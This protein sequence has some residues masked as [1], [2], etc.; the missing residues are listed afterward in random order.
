M[1]SRRLTT[2]YDQLNA[3]LNTGTGTELA[4]A[5][6]NQAV[7][8]VLRT[9]RLTGEILLRLPRYA[10]DQSTA[11]LGLTW[12]DQQLAIAF[13]PQQLTAI[14]PDQLLAL[15]SHEALHVI[16]RHPFRYANRADQANVKVACDIAVNQYLDQVPAGTATLG[17]LRRLLHRNVP[18]H[19]DSAF[20]LKL[21]EKA[22]LK[23]QP[24]TDKHGQLLN[25]HL[26]ERQGSRPRPAKALPQLESHLG[27]HGESSG[28]NRT[29]RLGQLQNLLKAAWRETPQH[30]RGLLPGNIR[31]ALEKP[32]QRPMMKW[33]RQLRLDLG[34]VA[35]GYQDSWGRFNRRQPMRMDLPGR[36]TKYVMELD[37]FV[38]N[39]GSMPNDKIS[40]LLSTINAL[41]QQFQVQATVYPFDAKVQ[42]QGIQQLQP[43]RRVDYR[44]VGGGGTSFQAIFDYLHQHHVDKNGHLVIIMTDGWGE[45]Q[46]NAYGY[47]N[48][49]WLLTTSRDQLSVISPP[50]RI[51][52]I[53]EDS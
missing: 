6:L 36:M 48:V 42:E 10:I 4:D 23:L 50:G 52:E 39:S 15:L 40:Q 26:D 3:Q 46:L 28:V 53:K 7:V 45:K 16:W 18:A 49:V 31:Q 1:A 38:D 27:W 30:D 21:I 5:Y 37:I 47:R 2:L 32:R 17:S 44:R 8:D 33:S 34:S 12:H 9:N 13:N 19:Q 24:T 29:W 25:R 11:V 22:H 35:R 43:G 51:I 20:Y 41:G 14:E